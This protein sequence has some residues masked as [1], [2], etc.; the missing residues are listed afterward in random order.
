MEISL[1]M[2]YKALES[3]VH[4]AVSLCHF[5]DALFRQKR[6]FAFESTLG[7]LQLCIY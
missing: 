4:N 1:T 7:G 3:A 6:A 5:V 2:T